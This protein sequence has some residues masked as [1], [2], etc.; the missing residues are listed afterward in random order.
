MPDPAT[1]SP[2][3]YALVIGNSQYDDAALAQLTTPIEDVNDLAVL[4]RDETIGGFTEV[5]T[6][7]NQGLP[8]I[9]PAVADFFADKR[10]DDLLLVYF[11]GH[12]VLDDRGRLYLAVSNTRRARLSGT[13]LP[14]AYITDEM[15]NSRSRRQVVILDCCHSGAFARGSKSATGVKAVTQAT[16]EGNGYGRTVLTATDATQ[17]AWEGDQVIGRAENSIFTHFLVEGLRTG[18][19]DDDGD[20]QIGLDEWYEYV[21]QKVVETTPK[22]T[23]GKWSY[24]QQ[25][26][27]VIARNPRFSRVKTGDLPFELVNLMVSHDS[28]QREAAVRWLKHLLAGTDPGPRQAAREALQQLAED[29]SR[30]V[31]NAAAQAL[32]GPAIPTPAPPSPTPTPA[33][34]PRPAAPAHQPPKL[35]PPARQPVTPPAAPRLETNKEASRHPEANAAGSAAQPQAPAKRRGTPWPCLAIIGLVVVVSAVLAVAAAWTGLNFLANSTQPAATQTMPASTLTQPDATATDGVILRALFSEENGL[36]FP[37][38]AEAWEGS[39][40]GLSWTIH[41]R[42]GISLASGG[43]FTA[44]RVISRLASWSPV[45]SGQVTVELVDD[46]T[47]QVKVVEPSPDFDLHAELATVTFATLP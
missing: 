15:D 8:A 30:R 12:G 28:V 23:P 44:Q 37:D 25:G 41:L 6:L 42:Q 24:K 33:A 11:S 13:A 31:A 22:Q 39:D 1:A 17:F 35:D 40:S 14:A 34:V 16:F 38:L 19:A 26:Q 2:R 27:L 7:I 36:F 21:Y 45:Q 32:A 18:A 9:Q 3:K 47:I 29:D 5:V 43:E 20:G 4:L 10:P 46:Y